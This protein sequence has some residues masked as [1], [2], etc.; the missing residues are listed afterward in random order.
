[1]GLQNIGSLLTIF[2]ILIVVGYVVV[3]S[4]SGIQNNAENELYANPDNIVSCDKK[5]LKHFNK[6]KG[7]LE[8]GFNLI[9]TGYC[10]ITV[11]VFFIVLITLFNQCYKK[12]KLGSLV[13]DTDI[14]CK[15]P[16]ILTLAVLF[17][18]LAINFTYSKRLREDKVAHEYYYYLTICSFLLFLQILFFIKYVFDKFVNCDTNIN[19]RL[20]LL[21]YIL[22]IINFFLLGITNVIIKFFS[23][24]G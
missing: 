10:T 1:M 2:L 9:I 11:S 14:A 15:L 23:T 19:T 22:G 16:G 18:K 6:D 20:G 24:D 7:P 13:C 12:D 17:Y 4:G 21:I 8:N 3:I 5:S